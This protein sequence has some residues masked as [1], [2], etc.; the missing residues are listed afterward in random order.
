MIK[1]YLK[2]L[3]SVKTNQD[4]KKKSNFFGEFLLVYLC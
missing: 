1:L 4:K 2:K 3:G